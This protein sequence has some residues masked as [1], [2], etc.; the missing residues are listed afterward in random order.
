METNEVTK[1][2]LD[3]IDKHWDVIDKER[4]E[5]IKSKDDFKQKIMNNYVE[6]CWVVS[7]VMRWGCEND[8]LQ[9]YLVDCDDHFVIKIDNKYFKWDRNTF[10]FQEATPKHKTVLYFD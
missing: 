8:Y 9:P 4:V 10:T 6:A 2:A 3:F 5:I 1:L 7:E